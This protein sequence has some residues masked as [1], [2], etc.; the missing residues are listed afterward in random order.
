MLVLTR[1]CNHCGL[2]SLQVVIIGGC[3]HLALGYRYSMKWSAL[4]KQKT[5][6]KV[7]AERPAP[8]LEAQGE[9]N[10]TVQTCNSRQQSESSQV[11]WGTQSTQYS[12][13]ISWDKQGGTHNLFND[14]TRASTNSCVLKF[15]LPFLQN[16]HRQPWTQ[17]DNR[18]TP[19]SKIMIW[20]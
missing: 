17:A 13:I 4:D 8:W 19:P 11:C 9:G 3:N 7:E 18:N 20:I 12:I 15:T 14:Q 6:F 10:W 5:T 1:G 16:L 2:F